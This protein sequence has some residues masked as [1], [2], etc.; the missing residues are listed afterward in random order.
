MVTML[1]HVWIWSE[2]YYQ[3]STSLFVLDRRFLFICAEHD[4][5]ASFLP[6][7]IHGFLFFLSSHQVVCLIIEQKLLT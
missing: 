4:D 5:Q 6:F 2:D 1:K 3:A 7:L